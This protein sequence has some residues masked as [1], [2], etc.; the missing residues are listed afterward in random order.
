[1]SDEPHTNVPPQNFVDNLA[2]AE[3][4][5]DISDVVQYIDDAL[6]SLTGSSLN[7]LEAEDG[8]SF[9]IGAYIKDT[10]TEMIEDS[11][12]DHIDY[13][14]PQKVCSGVGENLPARGPASCGK[15]D[16][17]SLNFTMNQLYRSLSSLYV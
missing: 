7:D 10:L 5:A 2:C 9:S 12:P 13:L 6:E 3:D 17:V 4:T 1:L 16:M 11:I 15:L 14:V 8:A